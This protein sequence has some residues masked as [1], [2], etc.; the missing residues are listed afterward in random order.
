MNNTL[1]TI[2][3]S[4]MIKSKRGKTGLR[5]LA[6]E[7]NISASTLSRIEQGNLPDIDTYLKI[8]NWLEVSSEYFVLGRENSDIDS[9]KGVIA[10]LRADKTL[11]PTTSEA[12]IQ[13]INLAYESATKEA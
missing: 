1:D 9:H 5:K 4:E 10:H 13:M 3:F 12:L 8:C 6:D 7:I 2:K 11:P